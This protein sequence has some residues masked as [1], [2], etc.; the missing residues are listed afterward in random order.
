M[1]TPN[2]FNFEIKKLVNNLTHF[3]REQ[4]SRVLDDKK[5]YSSL[6]LIGKILNSNS[7]YVDFD[8]FAQA[9]FDQVIA[10]YP[11]NFILI[12]K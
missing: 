4:S 3:T 5:C 2:E 7:I 10:N 1:S 12:K 11:S 8:I 6:L 9:R